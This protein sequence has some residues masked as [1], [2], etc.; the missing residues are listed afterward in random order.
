MQRNKT[1][2]LVVQHPTIQPR[3]RSSYGSLILQFLSLGAWV[4]RLEITRTWT[5]TRA[6][7]TAVFCRVCIIVDQWPTV[8]ETEC[9]FPVSRSAK[10]HQCLCLRDERR[11]RCLEQWAEL[12]QC[13]MWVAESIFFFYGD[14]DIP[15]NTAYVLGQIPLMTLQTKAK[16]YVH[17]APEWY[18]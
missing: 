15:D 3:R 18:L 13:R 6:N 1:L 4:V 10:H 17:L 7:T 8:T 16:M 14:A 11:P 12:L 2:T 5:R 9:C